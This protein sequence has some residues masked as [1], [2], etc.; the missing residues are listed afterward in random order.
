[1]KERNLDDLRCH[2]QDIQMEVSTI[3]GPDADVS[4]EVPPGGII[5]KHFC[6]VQL[7]VSPGSV[8]KVQ[9]VSGMFKGM[10]SPSLQ[11]INLTPRLDLCVD[12]QINPVE[13]FAGTTTIRGT[14]TSYKD[15]ETYEKSWLPLLA[16]E[17]CHGAIAND[18]SA[19]I[20]N[21]PIRWQEESTR[22]G[23]LHTGLFSL[24]LGFCKDRQIYFSMDSASDLPPWALDEEFYQETLKSTPDQCFDYLCVRYDKS[25][26]QEMEDDTVSAG[27]W[28]G[29]CYTSRVIVTKERSKLSI[30][31]KLN[32]SREKLP[33]EML[34][35]NRAVLCTVEWIS[36]PLP[37]RS[38][39]EYFSWIVQ[40]C[41]ILRDRLIY[42]GY[43]F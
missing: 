6:N 33:A 8:V 40:A 31:I 28:V 11:L 14:R 32:H 30:Q 18:D 35:D 43:P 9:V 34:R 17:A 5:E 38:G 22:S 42:S 24:S 7:G 1:M 20:H 25:A 13:C 39:C 10:L 3:R 23:I 21:V 2:I 29:H 12:H 19:I 16:M 36:R 15:P 37:M 41:V 26:N 4:S 27:R